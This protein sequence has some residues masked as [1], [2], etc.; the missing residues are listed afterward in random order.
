MRLQAGSG[1]TVDIADD[2]T[3][4]V[5]RDEADW[6]GPGAPTRPAVVGDPVE[7]VDDLGPATSVT[8]VD[9]DIRCS[10]LAYPERSMVVF[11]TTALADV[12]GLA[13]GAFDQ[14]SVG[15]PVF[16]PADRAAGGAPDDLRAV[17]FQHCEFG[18]PANAGADLDGFLPAPPPVPHR[19]AAPAVRASTA[20]RCCSPRSTP[21]T[22]RPW[23]STAAP[24]AA[25][26]TATCPRCRRGSARN[27]RWSAVTGSRMSSPARELVRRGAARRAPSRPR[28]AT[29]WASP[30]VLDRQRCGVLVPDRAGSRRRDVVRHRGRPAVAT[31]AGPVGAARQLVLSP[32]GTP[33]VRYR[34]LD[35]AAD[36]PRRRS[37]ARRAARR[38]RSLRAALG[39]P[40]LVA[41]CRHLFRHRHSDG[42]PVLGRR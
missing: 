35:R 10:V 15:W 34:R 25:A 30:L 27:W 33:A 11:R 14:P 3:V 13:T 38:H 42:V 19:L 4:R 37:H 31:R 24:C 36:G 32:R 20:G 39:G 16:T 41:H 7:V 18:L 8:V 29:S 40:P 23:A 9:G 12:D 21:S 6:F 2:G 28:A 26:G 5:G 17:A 1:L 22:S